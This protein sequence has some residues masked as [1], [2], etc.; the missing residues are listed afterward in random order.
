[1]YPTLNRR[2]FLTLSVAG[3]AAAALAACT[4]PDSAATGSERIM[5]T[6][7]AVADTESRR[8]VSGSTVN[9]A[10]AAAS[11][12]ASVA[13][14]TLRT[15]GFNAGLAGPTIRA[16]AGDRLRVDLAN[17]LP[18]ETSIHWH[19][20]A[21]RN[22][23]DG[24]QHITQAPV[25]AGKSFSYDF[26]LSHPGTYWYHSHVELQRERALYGALI[27]E[28]PDEPLIYDKD[29]V[30]ILDDW[31]DGI[32][33]TPEDVLAELSQ[34]M[35]MG[36]MDHGSMGSSPGPSGS[37]MGMKHMLMGSR[38]DFLGGDAGDVSYPF[39]LFNAKAP[40]DAEVFAAAAGEV[41]R[42]RIINAAGDTAY[43]V[44]I[45]EQKITLTHTDGFPV[46]HQDVDAVV[47]GMGERIDAL[48][49]V[50]EGFTPVLALPEG[51]SGKALG[52]IGT[53]TGKKPLPAVLPDSLDGTVLDGGQLKAD[54]AAAL[55]AKTPDRAHEVKL[56]GGMD[57]YDW[58]INGNRFDMSKPFEHAFDVQA[59]ERVQVAFVNDTDM[60]HPMH[61]H[62]HTFQVGA[63][64]ARKDTVIVRPKQ[65]VTVF[66]DADNPG[67]WL[68]HCHNAFHAEQ[69]MMALFSYVK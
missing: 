25:A 5:P 28:D 11:L 18:E 29:W 38:S 51:K 8:P 56:T 67:Q 43:R 47:L 62:G 40:D 64:G 15:W 65:T 24:V 69:G 58:G 23:Q 49:T 10:L 60:W 31:M 54:P 41:V 27:V 46:Q 44:G 42:L 61:L 14:K 9:Q 3:A 12:T 34:G 50:G 39:H 13:G 59:G 4:P 35:S 2:H 45:P 53:G 20:L 1:M 21:L 48:I 37:S 52:F 19:G 30:V 36:G 68:V 17:D 22:D 6:D 32:T 63:D 57:K 33:G 16:R 7:P 55:E 26:R 66:F